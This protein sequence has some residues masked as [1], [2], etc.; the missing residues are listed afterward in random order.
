[1]SSGRVCERILA[2]G[3]AYA[4]G[5]PFANRSRAAQS[6]T[7][8]LR[9]TRK[10]QPLLL[11]LFS[12]PIPPT[13]QIRALNRS[14]SSAPLLFP[15]SP[16]PALLTRSGPFHPRNPPATRPSS[17]LLTQRQGISPTPPACLPVW[18]ESPKSQTPPSL[19]LTLTLPS[20]LPRAAPHPPCAA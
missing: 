16:S 7:T 5:E 14:P 20:H 3:S 4:N 1:M 12:P 8:T 11:W 17:P 9:S 15:P 18:Q 19:S 2:F 6:D 13:H 10:W